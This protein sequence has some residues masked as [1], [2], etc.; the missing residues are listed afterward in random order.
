[1]KHS[2]VIA[3]LAALSWALPTSP[4]SA[5]DQHSHPP[6][7]R[8]GTVVFKNSCT[9]LVQPAFTRAVALLHSFAYSASEQAF[10]RVSDA[11]PRCAMAHWGIAMSYVHLMWEPPGA[12]DLARGS[13]ELERAATL[14]LTLRERGFVDAAAVYYRDYAKRPAPVRAQAY[15]RAMQQV[16][17]ANADDPEAQ[18]FYALALVATAPPTDRSHANDK[19]AA[20]IL[21]PL[22]LRFPDH[23]G[24]AHYLIHAYDSVELAARGLAAARAY[25][26]IAPAAPHALHM[27]SHIFTRLGYWDDSIESNRAARAAARAAGDL[28]EELHAMDF[29]TYA[30]LQ[31]GRELDA[32][33]VVEELAAMPGLGSPQSKI[34]FAATAMPVRLAI[35]RQ[36][37]DAAATL[38]PLPLSPPHVVALVYWAR[39][40]G[41]ARGGHPEAADA[42]I[43]KLDD[44]QRALETAGS[45]YWAGQTRVLVEEARA[46]LAAARGNAEE[47]VRRMRAAAD[48][49][50]TVEKLSVTPG[51]V[52]PAREQLGELLLGQQRPADA[53]KEFEAA[54]LESPGRRGAL[55]HALEAADLAGDSGTA[56]TLRTA[57][58]R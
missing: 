54:L 47:S 25:S 24:I 43:A 23:P 18:I 52:V 44:C 12:E 50:D 7:E 51:A 14:P 46:W 13:A 41:A 3:A 27:P 11:D 34:A 9:P 31:R 55:T 26:K 2:I 19:R 57:L 53:L 36:Q 56:G 38:E 33:Q 30:Y 16:A 22:Y 28:G 1:M 4:L 10:R 21:E 5:D 40:L 45:T 48:L 39:A 17:S 35:E 6:P 8:L 42:A 15:A 32:T 58:E 37:W 29:L 49:E 20:E